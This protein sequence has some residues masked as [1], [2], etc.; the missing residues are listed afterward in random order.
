MLF[1]LAHLHSRKVPVG[2]TKLTRKEI[3]AEDPV[4][5]SMIHII[6]F[7]KSN[8][9]MVGV[10]AALIVLVAVGV[11]GGMQYLD[12]RQQEAQQMLWKGMS[13]FHGDVAADATSD[14]YSKGGPV[15]S[16]QTETAKYQA[17]AKEFSS[18][19]SRFGYSK[20]S[21]VA[22]YYLGLS[23]IQLGQKK[24]AVQTLGTVANNSKDRTV[25]YLAKKALAAYY[26]TNSNYAGAKEILNG[27]IRDPQC[28]LPKE[29]LN[30]DLSKVLVAQG[31]RDE[32]VKVLREAGAQ[33]QQFNPQNQR[34]MMELEKLQKGS[35]AE[36]QP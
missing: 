30:I 26:L 18:V 29:D 4:H 3:L 16:F 12:S 25:G 35:K 20:I 33:G 1:F 8:G 28:D 13:Y 9:K 2:T 10:V 32:A 31:K 21:V 27:L 11:Y 22:N 24:E 15:P 14:P 17:A 19:V 5:E 7:F 23:Q 6:E 36:L 34:L